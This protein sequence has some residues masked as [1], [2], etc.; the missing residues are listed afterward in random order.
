MDNYII[1]H[2][3]YQFDIMCVLAEEITADRG[4]LFYP[5]KYTFV[6][7][8]LLSV[9]LFPVIAPLM[10]TLWICCLWIARSS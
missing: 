6:P 4:I 7:S 10:A 5:L 2:I 9:G 8:L 1:N 3:C